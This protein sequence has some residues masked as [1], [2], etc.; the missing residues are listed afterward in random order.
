MFVCSCN[1]V[2]DRVVKATVAAGAHTVDDVSRAC[3]AGASCGGCWPALQAL[4]DELERPRL[5]GAGMFSS[6]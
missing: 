1:A 4:I 2:S 5:V 6:D 3:G